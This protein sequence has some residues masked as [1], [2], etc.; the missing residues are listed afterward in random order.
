MRGSRNTIFCKIPGDPPEKG[1]GNG[2][3]AVIAGA[4]GGGI[5]QAATRDEAFDGKAKP[6]SKAFRSVRIEDLRY[7]VGQGTA[8]FSIP[9][10]E[11]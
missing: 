1:G 5:S 3:S 8:P 7:V 4:F 9:I 2:S 11:L 6:A 10:V